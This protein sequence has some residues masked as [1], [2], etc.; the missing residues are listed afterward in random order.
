MVLEWILK[1]CSSDFSVDSDVFDDV[2]ALNNY[3]KDP[4]ANPLTIEGLKN[5]DALNPG[6]ILD[7]DDVQVIIENLAGQR[8]L[9]ANGKN[10]QVQ[11]TVHGDADCDGDV[12]FDDIEALYRKVIYNE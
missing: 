3:L 11:E 4:D 9:W 5:A 12:D 7:H 8:T 6:T 10:E 2:K 1:I